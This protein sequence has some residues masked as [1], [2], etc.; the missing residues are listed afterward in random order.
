MRSQTGE[1]GILQQ[2]E[3]LSRLAVDRTCETHET[4]R[5]AIVDVALIVSGP[6]RLNHVDPGE[7][8]RSVP[9][10]PGEGRPAHVPAVVAC[11]FRLVHEQV[12][13]APILAGIGYQTWVNAQGVD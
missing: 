3:E 10:D 4:Q 12:G 13:H 6:R 5:L 1:V 11:A 8:N 7:R 2:L 9:P